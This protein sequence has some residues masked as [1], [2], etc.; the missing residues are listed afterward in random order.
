MIFLWID[1]N[2]IVFLFIEEAGQRCRTNLPEHSCDSRTTHPKLW[3][4]EQA[5][6]QNGVHNDIHNGTQA[7]CQ[8]GIE[9]SAGCLQDTLKAKLQKDCCGKQTA[10]TQ[11][12]RTQTHNFGII[13]LRTEEKIAAQQTENRKENPADDI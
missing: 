4:A 7:L 10:D 9:G 13:C 6:N 8:H 11:I 3:C 2:I 12:F 5:E 1:D